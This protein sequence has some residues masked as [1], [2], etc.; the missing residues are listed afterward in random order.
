MVEMGKEC[1]FPLNFDM[2]RPFTLRKTELPPKTELQ[3][4]K[5]ANDLL[6]PRV[7]VAQRTHSGDEI[8][9]FG[10]QGLMLLHLKTWP[11]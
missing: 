8:G 1:G 9:R 10:Q 2:P 7:A 3:R 6:Y 11:H 4:I 5:S